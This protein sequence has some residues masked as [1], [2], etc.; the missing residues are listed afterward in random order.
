MQAHQSICSQSVSQSVRNLME[1]LLELG[2]HH[3]IAHAHAGM[4]PSSMASYLYS[5]LGSRTWYISFSGLSRSTS[6]F[7][8]NRT[9]RISGLKISITP[10]PR[11]DELNACLFERASH[12]ACRRSKR[13][14]RRRAVHLSLPLPLFLFLPLARLV[15]IAGRKSGH[16]PQ[17][18]KRSTRERGR[19][20]RAQLRRSPPRRPPS[21][22]VVGTSSSALRVNIRPPSALGPPPT[23]ASPSD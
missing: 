10:V 15:F 5:H 6:H 22:G 7:Q 19:R 20:A 8:S 3:I 14:R 16:C 13:R 2:I 17:S 9:I 1:C 23:S 12:F 11:R 4:L 21:A 18:D